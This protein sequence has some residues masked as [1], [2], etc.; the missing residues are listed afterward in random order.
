M[1]SLERHEQVF[2][3][4]MQQSELEQPGLEKLVITGLVK[5][6]RR[7]E[8]HVILLL[9]LRHAT[10]SRLAPFERMGG[11]ATGVSPEMEKGDRKRHCDVQQKG[12]VE[13]LAI[14]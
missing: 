13:T 10:K 5:E 3:P 12:T 9:R 14:G 4:C 11:T 8:R 2:A 7:E 6:T 1:F